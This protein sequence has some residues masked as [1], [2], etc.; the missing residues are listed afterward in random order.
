MTRSDS[1]R[2]AA[3]REALAAMGPML[4]EIREVMYLPEADPRRVAAIA[5]KR[6]VLALIAV[7]E[8]RLTGEDAE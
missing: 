2:E 7:A 3:A 6:R 8:P 1:P 4:R 5:E